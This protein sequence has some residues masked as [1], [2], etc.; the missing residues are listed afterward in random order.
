MDVAAFRADLLRWWGVGRRQFPWRNTRDPYRVLVA[1]VLLHRTRA[2]Q[3]KGLYEDFLVRYPTL[4]SLAATDEDTLLQ[5][6]YSAGLRWRVRLLLNA[7]REIVRR[8]NGTIPRNTVDLESIDGIGHYIASAV[9]CFAFGEADPVIDTNT[10]RVLGRVYGLRI[11]DGLRRNK[12][13]HELA[14]DVLDSEH[15]REFNFALLD[16]AALICKPQAPRCT[17]CPIQPHCTYGQVAS[18]RR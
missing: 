12:S 2:E 6:L 8:F 11:T 17:E 14:R 18:T 10:V 3:V 7:A 1:E 5:V 4:H 16:L 15:P 9:R 13:F